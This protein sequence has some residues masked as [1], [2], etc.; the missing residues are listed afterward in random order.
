MDETSNKQLEVEDHP[1]DKG[2]KEWARKT[3]ERKKETK[4]EVEEDSID[5]PVAK[6]KSQPEAKDTSKFFAGQH[7]T[8]LHRLVNILEKLV[9][10]MDSEELA[11]LI[12]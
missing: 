11:A 10:K 2:P 1:K 3:E 12:E 4:H 9:S 5:Q 7:I 8:I 6:D